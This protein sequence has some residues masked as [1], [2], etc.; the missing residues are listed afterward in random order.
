[1]DVNQL[2]WFLKPS[3]LMPKIYLIGEPTV[4]SC[5]PTKTKPN[6]GPYNTQK[7]KVKCMVEC[8]TAHK[9]EPPQYSNN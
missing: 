4:L 2:S 9:H 1:M 3:E 6:A 5:C 8:S 7:I